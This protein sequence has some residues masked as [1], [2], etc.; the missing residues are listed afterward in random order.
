VKILQTGRFESTHKHAAACRT[1]RLAWEK[2]PAAVIS[3]SFDR[4]VSR[5]LLLLLKLLI[6][7]KHSQIDA[8]SPFSAML[9]GELRKT[10]ANRY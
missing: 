5:V 10:F 9:L 7:N 6:F 1:G 4:I 8:I 3:V 2:H